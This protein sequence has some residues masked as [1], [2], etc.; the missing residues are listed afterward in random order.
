MK[1]KC[2][3]T[4][5]CVLMLLTAAGCS[6]R[7]NEEVPPDSEKQHIRNISDTDF[8]YSKSFTVSDGSSNFLLTVTEGNDGV[9]VTAEDNKYNAST[10][11]ISAPEGYR[12]IYNNSLIDILVNDIDESDKLPDIIRISF[13]DGGK[14]VSRFFVVKDGGL[15]ELELRDKKN[16]EKLPYIRRSDMYRSESRRFI[17]RIVI[18]ESADPAGNISDAV[19]LFTYTFDPDK[20]SLTGRYEKLTEDNPLYFG[21]AYWGLANN[22]A[23]CFADSNF[24]ILKGEAAEVHGEHNKTLYFCKT[25]DPRFSNTE[26][27]KEY[28]KKIFTSSAA[29]KILAL[30]PDKITD[31]DGHLYTLTENTPPDPTK[32]MLTFT[33]HTL[34]GDSITFKTKQ[35]VIGSSGTV[36]GYSDG[37]D[38]TLT[39][40]YYEEYDGETEEYT[41]KYS[42]KISEYRY[43]YSSS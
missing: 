8:G 32:G 7:I 15:K 19:K 27:L 38:F 22:I 41:E 39:K 9:T 29:D 1:G 36:T 17:D 3:A 28:M 6:Q 40:S 10:L 20:L 11:E 43:P 4:G 12:P 23:S 18:D 2:A 37:G 35:E 16:G 14:Y 24:R 30:A 42:W 33:G 13:G 25:D 34:S 31:I 21:Y 26:E 5:L